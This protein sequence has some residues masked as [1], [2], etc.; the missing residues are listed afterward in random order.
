MQGTSSGPSVP[1]Q[2]GCSQLLLGEGV[3]CFWGSIVS[4]VQETPLPFTTWEG[5]VWTLSWGPTTRQG[6]HPHRAGSLVPLPTRPQAW[7]LPL[8][9]AGEL[10]EVRLPREL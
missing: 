5:K 8:A 10:R 4:G 6:N 2:D 3:S 7:R 9:E 1:G